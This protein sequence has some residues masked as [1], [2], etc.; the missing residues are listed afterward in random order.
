MRFPCEWKRNSPY[1]AVTLLFPYKKNQNQQSSSTSHTDIILHFKKWRKLAATLWRKLQFSPSLHSLWQP[2]YQLKQRLPHLLLTPEWP[3]LFRFL[4]LWSDLLCFYLSSLS[5][6]T[7]DVSHSVYNIIPFVFLW[8]FCERIYVTTIHHHVIY[9]L[10][11]YILDISCVGI[12]WMKNWMLMIE[13][14]G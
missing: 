12:I 5:S 11:L 10:N 1:Q 7:S 13:L 9:F 3:S 6:G 14:L 2:P 4:E 8:F